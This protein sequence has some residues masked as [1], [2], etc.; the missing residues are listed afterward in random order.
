[1]SYEPYQTPAQHPLPP[2]PPK[3]RISGT[4][5]PHGVFLSTGTASTG[6]SLSLVLTGFTI[7]TLGMCSLGPTYVLAWVLDRHLQVWDLSLPAVLLQV[8][9]PADPLVWSVARIMV[10]LLGFFAFLVLL[11]STPLA[12]HHAAEHMTV[13][14]IER[15]GPYMWEPYVD[16]M[17]RAHRRC[18]SNLLAG[19]LPAMLVGVPLL[20]VASPLAVLIGLMGWLM[21]HPLGYFLQNTFTTRPPT[22]G[23]LERGIA[24][25]RKLLA[26]WL[27]EPAPRLSLAQALW[28]RGVP[29]LVVGV[30][31]A[32]YAIGL[33]TQRFH[34]WL[35]W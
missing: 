29:Q 34:L 27:K 32:M 22:P 14:A 9:G 3:P 8:G 7:V 13:H 4:A 6:S 21:R 12:A 25:G 26:K 2:A 18:G 1:M 19:L 28:R 15:Y 17:P 24:S 23:Q 11:R 20:G 33:L 30:I 10:N 35:D 5:M 16:Q 31:I